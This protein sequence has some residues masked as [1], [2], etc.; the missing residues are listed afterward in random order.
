MLFSMDR[1]LNSW[2]SLCTA[3][4]WRFN[5]YL[6]VTQ[7]QCHLPFYF[8]PLQLFKRN[9][10]QSLEF[11]QI[12]QINFYLIM[13]SLTVY[14]RLLSRTVINGLYSNTVRTNSTA[15]N[16]GETN[17]NTNN[18][19]KTPLSKLVSG[20]SGFPKD[21]R[22]GKVRKG[23]IGDDAWLLKC[24]HNS[25][26]LGNTFWY[27]K[28]NLPLILRGNDF[29]V[30]V[31]DGVGGWRDYGVD[32]GDFSYSLLRSLDH[33]TQVAKNWH[34]HNPIALLAAA[35]RELVHSKRPITGK[36][37]ITSNIFIS[38]TLLLMQQFFNSSLLL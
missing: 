2:E 27:E 18:Q 30:V 3:T 25:D 32:P 1:H 24:V 12:V 36:Y 17:T 13:H 38:N 4:L 10:H 28:L 7:S 19:T 29:F 14:G 22:R 16:P 31:A 20:V 34:P 6:V 8:F 35:F 5:L 26:I 37:W 23:Q 33:I 11:I 21:I 9:K 15:T